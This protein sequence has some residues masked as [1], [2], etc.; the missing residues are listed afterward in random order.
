MTMQLSRRDHDPD[1]VLV[2]D[3]DVSAADRRALTEAIIDALEPE[4]AATASEPSA[5]AGTDVILDARRAR[6]F[7]LDALQALV[8]A[9][10]RAK[11]LRHRIVVVDDGALHVALLSSGLH[12]KFPIFATPEQ[13][14]EG[15]ETLRARRRQAAVG[16]AQQPIGAVA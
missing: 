8:A 1:H 7:D 13:A 14:H 6:S 10:A 2:I 12:A 16:L 15:L 11:W 3:G 4:T 5:R 9:R